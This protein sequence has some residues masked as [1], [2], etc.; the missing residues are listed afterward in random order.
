MKVEDLFRF[1]RINEPQISPDG[2]WVVYTLGKV[3]FEANRTATNLWLVSTD[4][5]TPRRVSSIKNGVSNCDWSPDGVQ[6]AC[7]SRT[8]PSDT[9]PE[10]KERSDVRHYSHISYK[11]NDTGW[12]D[13]KRAHIWVV[14]AAHGAAKQITSGDDWNDADPQ[15]SPD[16]TRIGVG[17]IPP[18][19]SRITPF[20]K[21]KAAVTM[22]AP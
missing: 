14:D 9:W 1:Q 6:A 4:G 15:W 2:K 19:P 11:F 3:N 17:R 22:S 18:P 7:L 16:S 10:G 12:Y 20:W 8:G 21:R 13:D 5:A